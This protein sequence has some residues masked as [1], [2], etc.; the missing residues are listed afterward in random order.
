MRGRKGALVL[1][2]KVL[3]AATLITV[4]VRS[5]A[6]DFGALGTVIRTPHLLAADLAAWFVCSVVIAVLRWRLLLGLAGARVPLGRTAMLQ[7]TALFFNVVI[8][9]NVGGDVVKAL[10]VARDQPPERRPTILLVVFVERFVGLSG[11]VAMASLVVLVKLGSLWSAEAFRPMVLTV[12]ALAGAFLVGP[13][14]LVLAVRRAGD[15]IQKAISGTSRLARLLGQL[16][17]SARLLAGSPRVLLATL[18]LSMALHG[19]GMSLFTLFTREL[20][21]QDVTYDQ[22]ATV[23]P[24]GLLSI[25]LPIAPAGFGVGHAAFGS[26]FAAIGLRDGATVF[27]VFLLGQI[28]PCLVGAIPYLLLRSELP[29]KLPD[30][31]A[32]ESEAPATAGPDEA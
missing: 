32:A 25:V 6:L 21:N 23:Y 22:I 27:N 29:T 19:I 20:T 13:A 2:L 9:G 28:A 15:R 26:L 3:V 18:A 12:G 11:L 14:L 1:A 31:A 8:P 30:E 4:L 16:V 5:G 10:Y 7:L 24:M 17:A